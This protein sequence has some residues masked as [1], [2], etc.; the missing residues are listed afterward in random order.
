MVRLLAAAFAFVW[1]V[2]P[3]PVAGQTVKPL[4]PAVA[5]VIDYQ[6]ILRDAKAAQSI[7]AQVEARRKRYQDQIAREEQRLHDE[8][9]ALTK[10]RTLLSAEAYAD[11]R[12]TFEDDVAEVQ[13][14]VQERRR[15]LDDVSS[16][17][18]SQVRNMLIEV[19]GELAEHAGF[20]V[21][22]PSSGVLLFS[23]RIDLTEEVLTRLDAK[24]P[25]VA[26]QAAASD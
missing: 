12:Q 9:K 26:L 13:R 25:D 21:V 5:A 16:A 10:Q 7:R 2:L 18:L 19:V 8:D 1:L 4:E 15:Q 17:A 24:L 6:R 20:N 22:L 14:M 23:P 3:A 11:K